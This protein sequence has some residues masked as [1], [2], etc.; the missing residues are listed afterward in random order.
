MTTCN[1]IIDWEEAEVCRL[2]AGHSGDCAPE[3][4]EEPESRRR[5]RAAPTLG[6]LFYERLTL[7]KEPK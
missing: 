4:P 6:D 5:P 1:R 7:L 3:P 2:S